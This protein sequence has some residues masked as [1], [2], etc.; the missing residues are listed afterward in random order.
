MTDSERILRRLL[1]TYHAKDCLLY[2]DDGEMQCNTCRIDFKRMSAEQIEARLTDLA[3]QSLY[4][5]QRA[6]DS[7][8]K[9]KH[10]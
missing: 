2:G 9:A 6:E 1:W 10:S 5:W 7:E 8:D 3:W 4:N